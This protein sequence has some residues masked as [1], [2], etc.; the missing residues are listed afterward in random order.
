MT[1]P[2]RRLLLR[3]RKH[4]IGRP[5]ELEGA[6]FLEILA[7]EEDGRA[8]RRV[9]ELRTHDRRAMHLAGDPRGGLTDKSDI[10]CAG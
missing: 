10:Q 8:G 5:A 4:G 6:D 9:E 7:L 1:T 2:R 3:K